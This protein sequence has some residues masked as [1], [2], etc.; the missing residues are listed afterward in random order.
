M[1][2]TVTVVVIDI[3]AVRGPESVTLTSR[4]AGLMC[5]V[6]VKVVG[7][8]PTGLG[9]SARSFVKL[10]FTAPTPTGTTGTVKNI[11]FR[12]YSGRGAVEYTIGGNG[13]GSLGVN[14]TVATGA[15]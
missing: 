10:T 14:A 8:P 15:V 11:A 1:G 2:V 13:P 3:Y 4:L 5:T 7:G 12:I 9:T 6:V